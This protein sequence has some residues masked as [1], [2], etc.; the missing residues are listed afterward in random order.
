MLAY[1]LFASEVSSFENAIPLKVESGVD[2]RDVPSVIFYL[3][4]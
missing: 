2:C 3:Y 1:M 4:F